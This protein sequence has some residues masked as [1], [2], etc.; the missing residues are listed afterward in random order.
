VEGDRDPAAAGQLELVPTRRHVPTVASGRGR[1]R[2]PNVS[3]RRDPRSEGPIGR[4]HD[5]V[6]L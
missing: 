6:A 3:W 4:C 1:H 5:C 2:P